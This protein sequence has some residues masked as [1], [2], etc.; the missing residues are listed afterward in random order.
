MAYRQRQKQKEQ[1]KVLKEQMR[2][3]GQFVPEDDDRPGHL[4]LRRGKKNT[5]YS[6]GRGRARYY[7][8]DVY[9]HKV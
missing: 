3:E 8:V 1:E 9:G 5:K 4:S 6:K 2:K 7:K